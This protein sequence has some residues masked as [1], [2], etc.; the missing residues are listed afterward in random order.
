MKLILGFIALLGLTSFT[1]AM[2]RAQSGQNEWVLSNIGDVKFLHF[3]YSTGRFIGIFAI[4]HQ[5]T[6]AL[7]DPKHGGIIWRRTLLSQRPVHSVVYHGN[8]ILACECLD[9][10][11]VLEDRASAEVWQMRTGA[12]IESLSLTHNES[13]PL[14]VDSVFTGASEDNNPSFALMTNEWLEVYEN[15]DKKMSIQAAYHNTSKT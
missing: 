1:L 2:T 9:A 15:F 8:C 5:G 10:L 13:K 7:L 12:M 11:I 6:L 3:F 4:T 14:Y